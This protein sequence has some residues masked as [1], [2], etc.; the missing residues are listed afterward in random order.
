MASVFWNA[1]RIVLVY[2][3][4]FNVRHKLTE[5]LAYRADMAPTDFRLS[6]ASRNSYVD[7]ISYQNE[8]VLEAVYKYFLDLPWG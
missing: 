3:H 4:L 5:H 6:Q 1:K 8:V 7:S 2:K